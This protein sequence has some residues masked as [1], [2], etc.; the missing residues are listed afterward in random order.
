MVMQP[1]YSYDRVLQ[2][3]LKYPRISGD[4]KFPSWWETYFRDEGFDACYCSFMGLYRLPDS[5]SP[6]MVAAF[7]ACSAWTFRI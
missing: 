6:I 5:G 1:P 2:D 4:G 3:S 7:S